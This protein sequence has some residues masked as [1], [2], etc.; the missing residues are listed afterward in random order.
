MLDEFKD[1][2]DDATKKK[3]EEKIKKVEAAR[4]KGE[5]QEIHRAIDELNKAAQEVFPIP[6]GP[7]KR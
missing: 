4:E 1:K 2:V 7:Q 5:P 3:I 6:R